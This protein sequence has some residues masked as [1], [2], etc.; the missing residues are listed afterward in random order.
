[1]ASTQKPD[2]TTSDVLK[3][4][5]AA[6]DGE[7]LIIDV[8]GYEGPLDMLLMLARS[9]K[10]DLLQ[11]SIL[12][13]A[14]QYLVYIEEL[15]V[16]RI[17]LA[18]DYLVMAAWLAYLKSRLI[19]PKDEEEGPS[20]EELAAILAFRLQRLE[21]MREAGAKLFA[22]DQLGRDVFARGDPQ[23]IKYSRKIEYECS[24][25][26]VLTGYAAVRTQHVREPFKLHRSPIFAMEE[27]LRRLQAVLGHMVEWSRLEAFLPPEM[28]SD[29]YRSGIASTF[30][31]GLELAREGKIEIQQANTFGPIFMRAGPA[32]KAKDTS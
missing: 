8:D 24:L 18:A 11:I 32:A 3:D 14:D 17:D 1:M 19:L 27:A 20:G 29:Q 7:A 22:R 28:R 30:A 26:E 9:Q 15:R 31:A 6:T 5:L 4:A 12:K 2:E 13:L 23:P 16:R 25:F 21:A 10:V